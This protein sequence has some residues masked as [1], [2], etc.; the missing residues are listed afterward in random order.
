MYNTSLI[1]DRDGQLIGK[2]RKVH[3]F[4]INIPG[5]AVYKESDTF[6]AGDS[7]TT[8]DTE[9]CRMGVAICYDLRFAELAQLMD[10]RGCKLLLYPANFTTTTGPQ[11]WELLLRARALDTQVIITTKI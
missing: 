5:K 4:D 3:L 9:Y 2:H 8:I 6:A 11:H 10:K 7:V 1:F